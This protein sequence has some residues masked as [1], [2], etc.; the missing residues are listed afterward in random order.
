MDE[1]RASR[2]L[3]WFNEARYGMFIHGGGHISLQ[4]FPGV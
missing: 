3:D 2:W 1:R 4:S